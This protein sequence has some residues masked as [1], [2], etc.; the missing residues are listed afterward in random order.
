MSFLKP[1]LFSVSDIMLLWN[2][3]KYAERLVNKKM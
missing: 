2:G 3:C 1:V